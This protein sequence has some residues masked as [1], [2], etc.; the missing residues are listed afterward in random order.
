MNNYGW[1]IQLLSSDLPKHLL[2]RRYR[3]VSPTGYNP[4]HQAVTLAA[5]IECITSSSSTFFGASAFAKF[6]RAST[7]LAQSM[8]VGGHL[9]V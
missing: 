2:N 4:P 3:P 7:R 5:A 1:K 9:P 6:F 8:A